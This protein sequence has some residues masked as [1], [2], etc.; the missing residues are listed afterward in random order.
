MKKKM[1]KSLLWILVIPAALVC[2]TREVTDPKDEPQEVVGEKPVGHPVT[3]STGLPG[4]TR[5]SH[6][7]D[8]TSIKV[9]WKEGDKLTV[10]FDK[11]SG[12]I[13]ETFDLV[14]GAGGTSATFRN[15]DSQLEEDTVFDVYHAS[16]AASW[17]VQDG[18]VANLPDYLSAKG[19]K[20][21]DAIS[22]QPSM[23]YFHIVLGPLDRDYASAY[24]SK[25]EGGCTIYSAPGVK[26][27]VTVTPQGGFQ[28]GSTVDFYVAV[29]IDGSTASQ[30]NDNF[31][32]EVSPKFQIG[33]A[34]GV[35][36][37]SFD[38]QAFDLTFPSAK[39]NWTPA[40]AYVA[41]KVYKVANKSL[42]TTPAGGN[43]PR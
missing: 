35:Q 17:A 11:G 33:F 31:G 25:M 29:M 39:C 13:T 40:K 10:M 38:G 28:A 37:I 36:G 27:G 23:T 16:G 32:A 1:H 34:N 43:L 3:L 2:C 14:N 42:S 9:A 7:L 19:V 15:E 24:L 20:L 30:A 6:G 26:G 12:Q 4:E 18:T 21:S 22:L 41:G 5:V 8:G